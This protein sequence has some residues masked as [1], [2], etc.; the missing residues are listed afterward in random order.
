MRVD[1]TSNRCG[2]EAG[3]SPRSMVCPGGVVSSCH[4]LTGVILTKEESRSLSLSLQHHPTTA[5]WPTTQDT[6]S[7]WATQANRESCWPISSGS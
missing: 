1:D 3:G 5:P 2:W 7:V 4:C 6:K